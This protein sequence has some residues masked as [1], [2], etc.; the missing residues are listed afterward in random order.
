MKSIGE[1]LNKLP[2]S[3]V[4]DISES[5]IMVAAPVYDHCA[6]EF[7]SMKTKQTPEFK[8]KEL[9]EMEEKEKAKAKGVSRGGGGAVPPV[10]PAPGGGAPKG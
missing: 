2:E 1:M 3:R 8:N 7:N 6:S 10:G 4:S 9:K 5:N